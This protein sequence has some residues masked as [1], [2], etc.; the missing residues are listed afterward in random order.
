MSYCPG[1]SLA[2][3]LGY[4]PCCET[5]FLIISIERILGI[6]SLAQF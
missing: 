4:G 1:F 6:L 5:D 3:C 2:L